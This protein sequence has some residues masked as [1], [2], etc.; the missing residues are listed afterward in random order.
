MSLDVKEDILV[1]EPFVIEGLLVGLF[2][3]YP[4]FY[5]LFSNEKLGYSSFGN[6]RYGW[7]F[8]LGRKMRENNVELFDDITVKSYI[9]SLNM[10]GAYSE[11]GGYALIKELMEEAKD[12]KD[13]LNSYAEIVLKYKLLR[14]LRGLFGDVV[15]KN[16]DKYNYRKLSRAT[17]HKYWLDKINL[18]S[19]EGNGTEEHY[20]LENLDESIEKWDKQPDIGLKFHNSPLMTEICSGW[21]Y[22]DVYIFGGFSGR[23]KT[24]IMF[25]KVIMSCLTNKEKLLI[26]AN[27]QGI[28][29][30][31][32][33]L[34]ITIFGILGINFNR[35]NLNKGGFTE[36]EKRNLQK[37]KKYLIENNILSNP[38]DKNSNKLIALAF[39]EDYNIDNVKNTIRHYANRGYKRIVIDTAKPTNGSDVPRWERFNEDFEEIYNM[40][41]P[42][43]GGLNLSLWANVQ[44]TD[45]ALGQRFLDEN[46]IGESKKIKNI[47]GVLFLTR[48]AWDDEYEGGKHEL[49]VYTGNFI[50]DSFSGE[51]SE[52]VIKLKTE[53]GPYYLLFTGKNRRGET[54][55]TGLRVLVLKPNFNANTWQEIGWA[56]VHRDRVY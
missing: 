26:I 43:G 1:S 49:K 3:S 32:K 22:G 48:V 34:F 30:F 51:I 17:I 37:A 21:A 11:Y 42:N 35:K 52:E 55:E 2:W 54:N 9:A 36:E 14:N 50:K 31:R 56:Y 20:L 27:E 13:N 8:S 12:S 40:I 24:S 23:G 53:D 44:L 29:E 10:M 16:T 39:M 28:E 47:A 45:S 19:I 5:D 25:N 38:N 7:F 33:M 6:V 4:K 18:L 15:I 41:R 46:A